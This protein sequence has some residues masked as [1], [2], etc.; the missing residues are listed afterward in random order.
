MHLC[1]VALLIA[2]L[3]ATVVA[4]HVQAAPEGAYVAP[5]AIHA[6]NLGPWLARVAEEIGHALAAVWR[7]TGDRIMWYAAQLAGKYGG[8]ETA[9]DRR[10]GSTP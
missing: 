9:A 8:E 10:G 2:V 1:I 4:E 3:G 5:V 7:E 6:P